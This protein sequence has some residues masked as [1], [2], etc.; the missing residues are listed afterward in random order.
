MTI[1]PIGSPME[2]QQLLELLKAQRYDA[3]AFMEVYPNL[4]K[5]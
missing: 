3:A 4:R 2:P 1:N 5:K